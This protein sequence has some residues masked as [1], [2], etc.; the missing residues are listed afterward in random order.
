MHAPGRLLDSSRKLRV[1]GAAGKYFRLLGDAMQLPPGLFGAARFGEPLRPSASG[2]S[3]AMQISW[4]A[5][6]RS[7]LNEDGASTLSPMEGI[8][9]SPRRP[10]DGRRVSNRIYRSAVLFFFEVE[11]SS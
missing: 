9:S 3:C 5:N 2:P 4:P 8:I 11:F 1:C 6:C 7:R 10:K